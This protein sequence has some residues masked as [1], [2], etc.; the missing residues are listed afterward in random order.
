MLNLSR[1]ISHSS[2]IVFNTF[3]FPRILMQ[4]PLSNHDPPI[5]YH[6]SH[7]FSRAI[8]YHATHGI[9]LFSV[10][11]C[12]S[13]ALA[14]PRGGGLGLRTCTS[15]LFENIGLVIGPNLHRNSQGEGPRGEGRGREYA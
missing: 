14:E 10:E 15:P 4:G 7:I 13:F 2:P 1:P 6:F 11:S 3:Y 12:Q 5:R 8:C 9:W